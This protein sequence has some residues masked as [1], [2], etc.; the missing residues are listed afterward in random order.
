MVNRSQEIL[1]A[2]IEEYIATGEPVSSKLLF[3]RHD[4]G[5]R[6]ATIRSELNLLEDGGYLSQPH[7]S[8]GREPTDRG[9]EFYIERLKTKPQ[10]EAEAP[11]AL[12]NLAETVLTGE[13]DDFIHGLAYELHTLSIGLALKDGQIARS[14]LDEL[15]GGL[16]TDDAGIFRGIAHE[17]ETLD[18]RIESYVAS[19]SARSCGFQIFIGRKGPLIKNDNLSTMFDFYETPAKQSFF[20][21]AIQPKRVNYK[22]NV[23]TFRGLKRALQKNHK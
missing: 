20:L 8:G 18:D 16:D 1:L 4:F 2:T 23:N 22:K 17:L 13:F 12:T 5:V 14:G 11:R 3:D 21:L 9:Y 7:T 19:K 6:P 15:F 10:R